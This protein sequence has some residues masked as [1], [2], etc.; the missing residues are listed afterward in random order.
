LKVVQL[1]YFPFLQLALRRHCH[2]LILAL[3]Q[4]LLQWLDSL[5][6]LVDLHLHV[7][8]QLR[9]SALIQVLLRFSWVF[10]GVGRCLQLDWLIGQYLLWPAGFDDTKFIIIFVRF[11]FLIDFLAVVEAGCG[12]GWLWLFLIPR[13]LFLGEMAF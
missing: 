7:D 4:L 2:Y 3:P 9:V 5:L 10:D 8:D 13:R 11:L 12:F 6:Q 1:D